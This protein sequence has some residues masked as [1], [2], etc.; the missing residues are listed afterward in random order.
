MKHFFCPDKKNS[1]TKKT[2]LGISTKNRRKSRKC[3]TKRH[4][5]GKKVEKYSPESSFFLSGQK[6]NSAGYFLKKIHPKSPPKPDFRR[7]RRQFSK[8]YYTHFWIFR[9]FPRNFRR[10]TTHTYGFSKI[11]RN[12]RRITTHTYGFWVFLRNFP[13]KN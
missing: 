9:I 7:L 6:K 11:S 10:I 12:F 13:E 8:N 2:P 3:R 5:P 4:N 1:W